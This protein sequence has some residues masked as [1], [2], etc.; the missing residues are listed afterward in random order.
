MVSW[1]YTKTFPPSRRDLDKL[2][3]EYTNPAAHREPYCAQTTAALVVNFVEKDRRIYVV[4]ADAQLDLITIYAGDEGNTNR[5]HSMCHIDSTLSR[6]LT[7][8]RNDPRWIPPPRG[9]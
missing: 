2:C 1:L 5:A 7:R 6:T 4:V 8:N 9:F 3:H